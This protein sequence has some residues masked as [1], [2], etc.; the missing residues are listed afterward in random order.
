[1]KYELFARQAIA[2][3]NFPTLYLHRGYS[4]PILI[5]FEQFFDP[6]KRPI[7]KIRYSRNSQILIGK[8]NFFPLKA[9]AI[10]FV[11]HSKYT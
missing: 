5:Q 9:L 4:M 8:N 2:K 1:M 10:F 7:F 3:K 6:M 11:L